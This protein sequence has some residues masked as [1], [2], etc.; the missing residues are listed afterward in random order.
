M[1]DKLINS[2]RR[3]FNKILSLNLMTFLIFKL[4]LYK[5]NFSNSKFK[6]KQK[7]KWILSKND[8]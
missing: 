2:S 5:K 3:K 6:K 1:Y 4:S 8:L 7:L